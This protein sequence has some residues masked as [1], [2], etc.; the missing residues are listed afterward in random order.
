MKIKVVD[1]EPNPF[2]KIK[3]YPI[4]R[5]KVEE[6][7]T[8]I[9]EKGF[10]GS[11][12]VREHNGKYELACGHHR[13]YAL[14]ELRIEYVE[15]T[16]HDDYND[17]K[18]I[19]V[20]AEENLDW[21]TSPV[22]MT[23]TIIVAKDFLNKEITKYE[24]LED[25]KLI[26]PWASKLFKNQQSFSA[27]KREDKK[28]I[29]RRTLSEFLGGNW[30]QKRVRGALEIIK[31]KDISDE[32]I[33]ILPT[34]REAK[35][36]HKSVKEHNIPKPTQKKIAKTI[37]KEGVGVRD[38]PDLVAEHSLLPVKKAEPKPLPKIEEFIQDTILK[39][40]RLT[41]EVLQ[42]SRHIENVTSVSLIDRM[43]TKTKIL[44]DALNE[45]L[46]KAKNEEQEKKAILH[47]TL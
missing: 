14:K 33:R 17:G 16:I 46:R 40:G 27:A 1:L 22:V 35:V 43:E 36:F 24:I 37:I 30:T 20:M 19:Q 9:K 38:I 12:P 29:G 23:Q 42:I 4:D 11:L 47:K 44:R 3:E 8:S 31:D 6:L 15:V 18:M 28:G 26:G 7:K 34:M 21:S 45:L 2:R 5:E 39:M 25:F 13:W 10:W 32:A 41:T